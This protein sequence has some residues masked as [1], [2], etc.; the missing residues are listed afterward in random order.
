MPLVAKKGSISA[1]LSLLLGWGLGFLSSPS[2]GSTTTD[3]ERPRLV[4]LSE[5]QLA[6]ESDARQSRIVEF[7]KIQEFT[8]KAGS[9]AALAGE[10]RLDWLQY[11]H[12]D[13]QRENGDSR[14]LP[15]LFDY[16]L[17]R[18]FLPDQP[19]RI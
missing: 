10:S 7:R 14:I 12:A 11:V 2:L 17:D 6:K 5:A 1:I 8:R 19:V 3:T 15:E 4:A 18:V 16:D 13:L 9:Q